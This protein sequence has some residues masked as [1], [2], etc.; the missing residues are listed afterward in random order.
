M[1]G[2]A[3]SFKFSP[4]LR[5]VTSPDYVGRS[6]AVQSSIYDE[7]RVNL[8]RELMG[9]TDYPFDTSFSGSFDSRRFPSHPEV[10]S[11]MKMKHLIRIR[12]FVIW[13]PLFCTLG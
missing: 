3:S 10:N 6:R 12:F 9:F 1:V 4:W 11:D 13:K 5:L 2:F 8:P 7:L